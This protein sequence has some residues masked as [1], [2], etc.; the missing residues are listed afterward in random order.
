MSKTINEINA[1]DEASVIK[2]VTE[3]DVNAFADVTG[4]LNPIHLNDE[5]ARKT[6]FGQRIAHGVLFLG[7][8][9]NVLGTQLPGQGAIYLKQSCK[10]VKPV[11]LGDTITATVKV[12]EKDI[13]RNRVLL[14]TYCTNQNGE[15]TLDGEA[16]M[17]L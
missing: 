17:M 12:I 8:I 9:S 16:L 7:Y 1:G 15:M 13:Q 5:Y 2:T 10:F 6:V 4:D 11:F 14:R 3:A